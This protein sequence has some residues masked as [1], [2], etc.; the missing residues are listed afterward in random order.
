VPAT[1]T[2]WQ[3]VAPRTVISGFRGR[4]I[5]SANMTFVMWDL[6]AGAVLPEHSHPHEQVVHMLSGELEVTVDGESRIL[7]AG[8][9]GVIPSHAV[10]SG[11]VLTPCRVMDAFYP[12]REDYMRQG[13]TGVL[14][15]AAERGGMG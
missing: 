12:L 5:H 11:R 15:A 2:N 1:V 3:D 10:H 4:F 6:E 7:R 8:D 9:V 13:G 14:Q